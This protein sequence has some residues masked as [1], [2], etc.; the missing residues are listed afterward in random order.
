ML[1]SDYSYPEKYDPYAWNTSDLVNGYIFNI[2]DLNIPKSDSHQC[3]N[4]LKRFFERN[5][6]G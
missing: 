3:Q 6:N 1:N 2:L 4:D 5:P